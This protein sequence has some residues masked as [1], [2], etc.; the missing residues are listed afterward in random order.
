[1]VTAQGRSFITVVWA[2]VTGA[3]GLDGGIWQAD[4]GSQAYAMSAA[5]SAGAGLIFLTFDLTHEPGHLS[6]AEGMESPDPP[7][8]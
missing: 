2:A 5:G 7:K 4:M 8:G 3:V 1:M 6:M